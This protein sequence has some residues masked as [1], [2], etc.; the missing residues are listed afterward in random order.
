MQCG[1]VHGWHAIWQDSWFACNV[2]GFMVGMQ[3]GRVHE[4]WQNSWLV[5]NVAEFMAG[6][7]CGVN[8]THTEEVRCLT[9]HVLLS[10]TSPTSVSPNPTDLTLVHRFMPKGTITYI[11][12]LCL[13]SCSRCCHFAPSTRNNRVF[14][15]LGLGTTRPEGRGH[16]TWWVPHTVCVVECGV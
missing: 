12:L 4:I 3:R 5:C 11:P 1:R 15:P 6:M 8:N 14:F 7:Q 10:L 16:G 13:I 2:A 9:A